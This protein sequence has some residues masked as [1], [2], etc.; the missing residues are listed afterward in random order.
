MEEDVP[1]IESVTAE[2]DSLGS[3]IDVLDS[4]L[5]T[6][7]VSVDPTKPITVNAADALRALASQNAELIAEKAALTDKLA[8]ADAAPKAKAAKA[9]K[10]RKIGA[11]D[12]EPLAPLELL[13]LIRSAG[14]VEVA[15]SDGKRELA[16]I[17]ARVISGDAW[18][19]TVAGLQLRGLDIELTGLGGAVEIVGYGLLL[20][21]ELVAYRTRMDPLLIAPGAKVSLAGDIVF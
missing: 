21:G 2:R 10:V 12:G 20:D 19:V 13:E 15:F 1:T 14:T 9:P 4:E 17:P 18:A 8:K 16:E 7:G 6:I 11:L 3:M 5:A